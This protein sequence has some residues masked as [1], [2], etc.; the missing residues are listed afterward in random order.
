M[1]G[2]GPQL[3]ADHTIAL[4]AQV[5]GNFGAVLYSHLICV[6]IQRYLWFAAVVGD[7]SERLQSADIDAVLL[8]VQVYGDAVRRLTLRA[9][10]Y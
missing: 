6:R 8:S 7:Q 3:V 10:V 9:L 2:T 5:F 4:S 1:T